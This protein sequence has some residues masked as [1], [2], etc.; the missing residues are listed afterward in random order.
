MFMEV[1]IGKNAG[2]CFGVD[3]AVQG[4][5]ELVAKE[6]KAYCLGELV[7][8]GQVVGALEKNGMKTIENL[9]EITDNT[10]KVIFRAHGVAKSVYEQAKRAGISYVDL[11][12]PK[13]LHLHGLAEKHSQNGAFVILTGSKVHP[14]NIGTIS[15]V[16]K[17]YILEQLEGVEEAWQAYLQSGCTALALLS[18]TTY[19]LAKFEEI[20]QSLLA[21]CPDLIVENTICASTRLR[22]EETKELAQKVSKMVIIGGKN[23]SNT[24]KLYEV[25]KKECED[26]YIVETAEEL[27]TADFNENDVVGIMAG[28]STPKES[29]CEVEEFLK[30]I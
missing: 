3:R 5:R 18:Q 29:I 4:A 24:K 26:T 6:A 8:N 15:V 20:K 10:Q 14:E 11:T 9:D 7:H 1:I 13:V 2:F 23:S 30:K 27:N 25:A 12:C 28:A 19:S 17:G 21:K 22:Q 16:Q